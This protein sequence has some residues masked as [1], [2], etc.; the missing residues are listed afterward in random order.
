M[1][2][3]RDNCTQSYKNQQQTTSS[4]RDVNCKTQLFNSSYNTQSDDRQPSFY[5]RNI[6]N[7][8]GQPL[9]YSQNPQSNSCLYHPGLNV[10]RYK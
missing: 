7:K 4:M 6:L 1:R 3:N 10:G 5:D 8:E 9:Y 2:N